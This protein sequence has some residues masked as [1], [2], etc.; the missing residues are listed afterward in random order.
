MAATFVA[1]ASAITFAATKSML[2]LWNG[3]GTA[4]VIRAYLL[5]M[6]N[7][8]TTGVTGVLTTMQLRRITASS[9][10][11]SVT[12]VK[13][14]TNSSNLDANTTSAYGATVT[15]SDIF[16]SF[17][18]SNEEPTTI[19]SGYNNLELLVPFAEWGRYGV[20]SSNLEPIVCRASQGV[21]IYHS[22]SSTVSSVDA[23]IIF[24]DAAS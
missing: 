7:S 15:G 6:F 5:Y 3:A 17:I 2:S 21:D 4:R 9:S 19:G 11:T 14:D 23:E 22:G 20:D 8:N 24:T 18:W 13:F 16:R 12:P 10:G 1:R